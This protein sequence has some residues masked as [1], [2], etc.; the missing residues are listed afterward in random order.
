MQTIPRVG[1]L[2][3]D[4]DLDLERR[5][6]VIQRIVWFLILLVLIAG[7]LGAFG[8]G[9]L[10]GG[11]A[12]AGP[13]TVTYER[14]ARERAPAGLQISIAPEAVA[15][16]EATIWINNAY[17]DVTTIQQMVPEPAEMTSGEDRTFFRFLIAGSG[18]GEITLQTEPSEP[19]GK[20]G[21]IGVL[22]GPEITFDQFVYP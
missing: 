19:G 8:G 10:S 4:Q 17:L 20:T 5:Q 6:W 11:S 16:G 18:P 7:L 22:D 3:I 9:W 1:S 14:L 21:Q 15:N 12:T 13:L 2:E